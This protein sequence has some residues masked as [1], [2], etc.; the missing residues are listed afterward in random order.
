MLD[1]GPLRGGVGLIQA[2]DQRCPMASSSAAAVWLASLANRKVHMPSW[3][4]SSWVKWDHAEKALSPELV[5]DSTVP[6]ATMSVICCEGSIH[7]CLSPGVLPAVTCTLSFML[8][9]NDLR[10]IGTLMGAGYLKP[11]EHW[12]VVGTPVGG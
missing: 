6:M 11:S 8:P 3:Q 9:I 1:V 2:T 5:C 7:S 4:D 10:G 12:M